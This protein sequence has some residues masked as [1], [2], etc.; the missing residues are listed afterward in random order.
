MHP[1]PSRSARHWPW[2]PGVALLAGVLGPWE[3]PLHHSTRAAPSDGIAHPRALATASAV[4]HVESIDR[5]AGTQSTLIRSR[6]RQRLPAAQLRLHPGGGVAE[7]FR[8]LTAGI[9]GAALPEA[10]GT[11]DHHL[12]SVGRPG[13]NG[14]ANRIACSGSLYLAVQS[15]VSPHQTGAGLQSS[16]HRERIGRILPALEP[17][18]LLRRH[19]ISFS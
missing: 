16:E 5:A 8:A 9:P 11:D 15:K 10:D 19:P 1:S 4:F 3:G 17:G 13:R 18:R 12:G 14:S 2:R 6:Y 7:G